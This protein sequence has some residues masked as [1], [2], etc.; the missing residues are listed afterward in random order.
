M[1]EGAKRVCLVTGSSG[2]IGYH[3]C[4][5]F[6]EAGF[7]VVALDFEHKREY[8][9]DIDPVS[10]DLRSGSEV[11]Y[12]F[13]RIVSKYGTI[14]VLINNAALSKF[15]KPLLETELGEFDDVINV[16][17]RGSF[18][19]ARE[20]ARAN[21]GQDYGRIIN[22]SSTRYL[23]NEP[24]WEAYGASKG[25]L[26]SMA[27]G[28]TVSLSNTPVTVNTISLGWIHTNDSVSLL[29]V[30]HQQ[31]PSGRVGKPRDVL[32]ACLFFAHEENDFINGA[33]L[34]VDGGMTRKMIYAD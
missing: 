26:L 12:A 2:G 7:Q 27:T 13:S 4:E 32:N 15:N 24:G 8:S 33:N 22:I 30:D 25:G 20:F 5:G 17:L 6:Q 23:Q 3:L 34:I 10:V 16:N 1:R 28:L 29:P 31:H 18:L 11:V 19:C 21:R 9:K 14:H